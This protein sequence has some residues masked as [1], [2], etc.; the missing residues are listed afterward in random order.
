MSFPNGFCG[1]SIPLSTFLG[2]MSS[3]EEKKTKR[4]DF[5]ESLE[6]GNVMKRE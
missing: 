3:Q 6:M 1:D 2:M 5:Q 4:E